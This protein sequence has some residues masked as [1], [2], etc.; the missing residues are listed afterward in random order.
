[1]DFQFKLIHFELNRTKLFLLFHILFGDLLLDVR[2][3][4]RSLPETDDRLTSVVVVT[5]STQPWLQEQTQ[6][7]HVVIA[8]MLR[9]VQQIVDHFLAHLDLVD[10]VLLRFDLSHHMGDL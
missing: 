9:G 3:A 7:V 8:Q 1:M 2:R 6:L 10:A 5:E 4:D